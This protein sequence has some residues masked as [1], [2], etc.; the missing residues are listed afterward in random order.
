MFGAGATFAHLRRAALR[1]KMCGILSPAAPYGQ[2]S[3]PQ[4]TAMAG[5]VGLDAVV[6]IVLVYG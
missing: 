2:L 4:L 1:L 3:P 5:A 6:L